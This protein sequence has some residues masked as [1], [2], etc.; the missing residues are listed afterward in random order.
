[1]SGPLLRWRDADAP[2][3]VVSDWRSGSE[4]ALSRC[5]FRHLC[6]ERPEELRAMLS[7]V[8]VRE[9]HATHD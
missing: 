8:K 5:G 4:L 1:M 6:R 3:A 7:S 9:G 2:A